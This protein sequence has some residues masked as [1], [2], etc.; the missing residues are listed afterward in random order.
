MAAVLL[1][2][3]DCGFCT[4]SARAA[5]RLRCDVETVPWQEWEDRHA[6]GLT[7]AALAERVH[8]VDGDL[9]LT[10]HEAIGAALRRSRSAPVRGAGAV[11][12]APALRPVAAR[13]YDWVAA[14]R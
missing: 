13:V 7:D 4:Q 3:R 5:H 9:V 12:L 14:H 8:L 11:V 6:R 1:Y 10:G 2:A